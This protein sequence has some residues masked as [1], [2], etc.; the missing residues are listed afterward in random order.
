MRGSSKGMHFGLVL[1][2]AASLL[3]FI[4]VPAHANTSTFCFESYGG[5]NGITVKALEFTQFDSARV[6]ICITSDGTLEEGRREVQVFEGCGNPC[7]RVQANFHVTGSVTVSIEHTTDRRRPV[8]RTFGPVQIDE[9]LGVCVASGF[10]QPSCASEPEPEPD[11]QPNSDPSP[12]PETGSSSQ[13]SEPESSSGTESSASEENAAARWVSIEGYRSSGGVQISGHL[14]GPCT[15]EQQVVIK[16][17]RIG[18]RRFRNVAAV[19]T[20]AS[21]DYVFSIRAARGTSFRAVALSS[22]ECLRVV[23][24]SLD[25]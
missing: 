18:E 13:S 21:G 2:V 23:S 3:A 11:T 20:D 7:Y 17:R 22:G 24:S 19:F 15:A 9:N 6:N 8:T 1:C 16:M 10:P 12:E 4:S 5:A 25:V 14:N